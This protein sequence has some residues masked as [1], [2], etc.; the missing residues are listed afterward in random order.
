MKKLLAFVLSMFAF[1]T[2]ASELALMH[3]SMKGFSRTTIAYTMDP[4]YKN[5]NFEI[6]PEFGLSQ[7]EKRNDTLIQFYSVPKLRYWFT[8]RLSVDGG[9]G[10]S[11][12]SDRRL[13][14][15]RFGTRFQ[16]TDHIGVSY[17]VTDH[18]SV[19]YRFTHISNAGM[20]KPNP[21][22]DMQQIILSYTF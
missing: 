19:G 1:S 5:G 6:V 3:G 10:T 15:R 20:K 14:T 11:F 18:I 21:G 4:M 2:F 22:I 7:Y 13:D 12:L 16:F 8:D 17:L 9:I